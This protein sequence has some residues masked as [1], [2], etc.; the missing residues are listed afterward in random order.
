MSF[1][2]LAVQA[3]QAQQARDQAQ[4]EK[5]THRTAEAA[6]KYFV[7]V[8]GVQ[9]DEADGNIIRASGV[10]L[11][12]LDFVDDYQR[13]QCFAVLGNCPE[14]GAVVAS[15]ECYGLEDIGKFMVEFRP[16]YSHTCPG[17]EYTPDPLARIAAALE[18]IVKHGITASPNI[19]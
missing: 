13:T 19:L 7:K 5:D 11:R 9:P 14:C 6:T 10:T 12:Y 3:Y 8:F 16:N 2:D 1:K 4:R 18:E 15:P 17:T